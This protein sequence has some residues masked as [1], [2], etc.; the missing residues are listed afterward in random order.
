MIDSKLKRKS[1][2]IEKLRKGEKKVVN[3]IEKEKQKTKERLKERKK[4]RKKDKCKLYENKRRKRKRKKSKA[5][6]GWAFDREIT[7]L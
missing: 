6:L 7:K 2:R 3:I 4:E 5:K 1:K